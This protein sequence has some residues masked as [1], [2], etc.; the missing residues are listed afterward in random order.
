MLRDVRVL[1]VDQALEGK[2][3]LAVPAHTATLELT[4]KQSEVV[5]L[6]NEL[7]NGKL[8]L[9]L[10]SLVP[11]Q[12]TVGRLA[13]SAHRAARG[14]SRAADRATDSAADA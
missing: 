1:A 6:A 3:G 7:A 5:V 9:S 12:Q 8:T 2:P 14:R 4:Q 11:A 13:G 10:R